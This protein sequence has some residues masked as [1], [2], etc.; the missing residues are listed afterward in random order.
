MPDSSTITVDGVSYELIA[1]FPAFF[2][3]QA[4]IPK[5][6]GAV[7]LSLGV[8]K[9]G[10]E[11]VFELMDT[12]GEVVKVLVFRRAWDADGADDLDPWELDDG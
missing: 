3:E 10:R 7:R 6:N 8:P 11:G 2:R 4:S 12:A 1:D 9:E 5:G